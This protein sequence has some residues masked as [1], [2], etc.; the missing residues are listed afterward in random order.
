[1][2]ELDFSNPTETLKI[3]TSENINYDGLNKIAEALLC[4]IPVVHIN[5]EERK[6]Q[7]I[8]QCILECIKRIYKFKRE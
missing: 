3:L 1:M 4:E 6:F 2:P 8:T 5:Q 7:A